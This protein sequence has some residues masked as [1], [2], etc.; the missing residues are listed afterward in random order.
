MNLSKN[1]AMVKRAIEN[2]T[3]SAAAISERSGVSLSAIT[4]WTSGRHE[5][6]V[7]ANLD[8]VMQAIEI[9]DKTPK[10]ERSIDV[11][12]MALMI[13][14]GDQKKSV[15]HYFGVHPNTVTNAIKRMAL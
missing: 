7:K 5:P 1:Q 6:K 15:A 14:R 8:A 9:L 2:S 12:K 4:Y 13:E 3:H 11:K 10:V